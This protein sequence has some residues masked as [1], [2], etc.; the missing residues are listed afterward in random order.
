MDETIKK[1]LRD[2]GLNIV[3]EKSAE[4]EHNYNECYFVVKSVNDSFFKVTY[5]CDSY[6][7]EIR[8]LQVKEVKP[9]QVQKVI[10]E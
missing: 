7:D 6:G 8:D 1:L 5:N 2:L 3:D 9:K 4:Y 10:Y